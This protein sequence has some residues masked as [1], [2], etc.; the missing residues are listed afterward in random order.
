MLHVLPEENHFSCSAYSCNDIFSS[1]NFCSFTM[2]KKYTITSPM[3]PYFER[4]S[5][6]EAGILISS[7]MS[8]SF[9]LFSFSLSWIQL[10]GK[11]KSSTNASL[12][13]IYVLVN[14]SR[15]AVAF[16]RFARGEV[17]HFDIDNADLGL[18]GDFENLRFVLFLNGEYF[19]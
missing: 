2:R 3:L 10:M 9:S 1:G 13:A 12:S 6:T 4:L 7:S 11:Y 17:T 14:K 8:D 19:F 16:P 15:A 18:N 5:L